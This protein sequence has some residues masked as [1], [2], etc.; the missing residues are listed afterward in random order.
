[1][2]W[3][4][5]AGGRLL[6]LDKVSTIEMH[7]ERGGTYYLIAWE[8]RASAD[9]ES[10][11]SKEHNDIIARPATKEEAEA[12]LAAIQKLLGAKTADELIEG[13]R[14]DESTRTGFRRS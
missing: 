12:A 8:P 9:P 3:I 14:V 2:A 6:N 11:T 5:T 7:S 1:M 4:R 10:P 13:S